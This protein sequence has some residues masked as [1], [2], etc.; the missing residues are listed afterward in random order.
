MSKLAE[1]DR[2][3]TDYRFSVIIIAILPIVKPLTCKSLITNIS[4]VN[5]FIN[6]KMKYIFTTF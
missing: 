5:D 1:T 2:E 3:K 6:N 4:S